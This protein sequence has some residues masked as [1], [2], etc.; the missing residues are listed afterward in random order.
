[1]LHHHHYHD[2]WLQWEGLVVILVGVHLV[3]FCYWCWLLY[4]SREKKRGGQLGGTAVPA[5]NKFEWR[6]PRDVLKAR[7]GKA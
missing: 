6:T 5:A 2:P 3:A 1:M 4:A 7:L